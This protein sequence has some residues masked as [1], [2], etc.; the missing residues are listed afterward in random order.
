VLA[1]IVT[2]IKDIVDMED[3]DP[4][5]EKLLMSDFTPFTNRTSI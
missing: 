3:I 1:E 5:A 4:V 2:A